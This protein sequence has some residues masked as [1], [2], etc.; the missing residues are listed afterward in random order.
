MLSVWMEV[1]LLAQSRGLREGRSVE[2]GRREGMPMMVV[3]LRERMF[4]VALVVKGCVL[5]P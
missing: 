3:L 4:V 2:V 5:Q 1:L